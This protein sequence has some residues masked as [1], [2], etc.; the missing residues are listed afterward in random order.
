MAAVHSIQPDAPGR[1]LG[2]AGRDAWTAGVRPTICARSCAAGWPNTT[3]RSGD[4]GRQQIGRHHRV[5]DGSMVAASRSRVA[6]RAKAL[7][8]MDS[9]STARRPIRV[10]RRR[11]PGRAR[12]GSA[13][14]RC[15]GLPAG[16]TRLVGRDRP[17][18]GR[19]RVDGICRRVGGVHRSRTPAPI[20]LARGRPRLGTSRS[21]AAACGVRCAVLRLD[22][23]RAP[24]SSI[25]ATTNEM[26]VAANGLLR[27]PIL[28]DGRITA[29]AVEGSGRTTYAHG[30]TGSRGRRVRR[31]P[32]WRIRKSLT[33][34]SRSS[35]PLWRFASTPG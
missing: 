32:T 34:L 4:S 23:R 30:D 11:G 22:R 19:S 15:N 33:V 1:T 7:R 16:T 28:L 27:S 12:G 14:L 18:A 2:G 10:V 17:A 35:S 9:S 6:G 5:R 26:W 29:M 24:G 31:R 13:A 21:L 3:L 8:D 25:P 20:R